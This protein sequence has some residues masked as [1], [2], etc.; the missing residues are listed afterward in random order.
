MAA[1]D[2]LCQGYDDLNDPRTLRTDP[3]F[4]TAVEHD[5][6]LCSEA[7]L[8]LLKNRIDREATVATHQVLLEQ[9]H[10]LIR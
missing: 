9:I 4:Q 1:V 2:A 7:T 3:A 6:I 10:C 8:C 5:L